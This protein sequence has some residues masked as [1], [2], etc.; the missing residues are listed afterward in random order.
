MPDAIF[1]DPRLAAVYD[2]VDGDRSD[3]D[4][5]VALVGELAARTVVDV[6]CGTG[7]LAVRLARQGV[8]VVGLDPAAASLAVARAKPGA[9]RVR[10]IDGD[11]T[12]LP[13]LAADLAV[14]AGNVAQV[15]LTDEAWGTTLAAVHRAL[16]PGGWLV[17]ETRVPERRAR[18][19]WTPEHT[20]RTVA[21]PEGGE[22][23]VCTDLLAD[24][25][26][27]V[28]FRHTY[29]FPG[30]EVRRSEST[31]RFRSRPELDA[32]LAEAGFTV[33][34]V[35]DAPDRPGFEWVVLAQR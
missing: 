33:A 18:R 9:A 17:F 1:A 11:A 10:W 27:L 32:S 24:E 26:P 22:L 7:S 19:R 25:L 4:A 20:R 13:D 5:Y 35:R 34:E 29:R 21:L 2:L 3:L 28:S 31:L 16:R 23:E 8:D 12:A 15:F 6:G 14:M 30:G